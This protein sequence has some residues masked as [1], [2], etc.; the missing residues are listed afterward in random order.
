MRIVDR[1]VEARIG[2]TVVDV[3]RETPILALTG[4]TR[5]MAHPLSNAR[6]GSIRSTSKWVSSNHAVALREF[7]R[8]SLLIS[9][10]SNIAVVELMAAGRNANVAAAVGSLHVEG[11]MPVGALI[12]AVA[13]TAGVAHG[14]TFRSLER[15]VA[16]FRAESRSAEDLVDVGGDLAGVDDRIRSFDGSVIAA[17][18]VH[19]ELGCESCGEEGRRSSK[20]RKF[21][22]CALRWYSEDALWI[23]WCCSSG[24]R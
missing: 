16:E 4:A 10:V 9:I 19:H 15:V 2:I 24:G 7:E 5:R 3:R 17:W 14:G 20:S 8:I 18:S 22:H 13:V 12:S 11:R 6:S 21:R 23:V 1:S